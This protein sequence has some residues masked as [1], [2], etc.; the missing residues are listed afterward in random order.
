VESP[1][2]L[3]AHHVTYRNLG[4]EEPGDVIAICRPCH[5]KRHPGKPDTRLTHEAWARFHEERRAAEA[6][7][8][9][10]E[11]QAREVFEEPHEWWD[12]LMEEWPD[13]WPA[14]DRTS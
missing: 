13:N 12:R 9:Y 6:E 2:D 3:D 7:A 14:G 1:K 5:R 10:E 8:E 11:R 4:R